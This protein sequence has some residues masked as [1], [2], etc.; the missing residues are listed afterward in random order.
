MLKAASRLYV[1]L[2]TFDLENEYS[3]FKPYQLDIGL[4]SIRTG[5]KT[6]FENIFLNQI[7]MNQRRSLHGTRRT[8]FLPRDNPR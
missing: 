7:L 8:L 5:A 6:T 2:W 1:L 4:Y 3:V